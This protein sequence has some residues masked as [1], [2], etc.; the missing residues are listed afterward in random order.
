MKQIILVAGGNGFVGR[1]TCR[2][3]KSAGFE[4]LAI[5]HG[6]F[7]P[8][9]C[10]KWGI[11]HWVSADI[12]LDNLLALKIVPTVIVNCSGSGS[13]GF[14]FQNPTEDF[15]KTV[16]STMALLEFVRQ[17]APAAKFIQLSSPAVCGDHEDS[18]IKITDSLEPISPYG[19]HKKMAEDAC[20]FYNRMSGLD[21]SIIRFFSLYGPG[22]KKQLFWDAYGKMRSNLSVIE[23][24]GTGKET[25]DWLYID[26]AVDLILKVVQLKSP[27]VQM[28]NGAWGQRCS[29]RETLACFF[30]VVGAKA[31][32]KFNGEGRPGD[33]KFYWAEISDTLKLG[34]SP[35][36]T[37][38]QGIQKY[39]AW[40]S[41]EKLE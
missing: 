15:N 4:V 31:D 26:D 5:G 37:L 7:E 34:W 19:F 12:T 10:D 24:F 38:K 1:N 3:F 11:D 40:V 2:A 18:P 23:F 27:K 29:I 22:L 14:S 6:T 9:Q 21:I 16:S 8:G 17:K 32:L 36:I 13:V 33:P 41:Q 20:I 35:S 25:R 30:D 28:F 39:V